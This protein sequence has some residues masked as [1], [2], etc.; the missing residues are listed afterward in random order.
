LA[1]E[2][3]RLRNTLPVEADIDKWTKQVDDAID[4]LMGYAAGGDTP[5][6]LLAAGYLSNSTLLK[7]SGLYQ[8][9]DLALST[10]E[11]GMRKVFRAMAQA[12]VNKVFRQ[13][14]G[15]DTEL[16]SR[17]NDALNG[18][19][20]NDLRFKWL[21][22]YAEDNTDLTRSSAIVGTLRNT[23]QAAHTVNGLRAAHSMLVNLNSGI[24]RDSIISALKGGEKDAALL[25]RF[26]MRDDMLE[27]SRAAYAANPDAALPAELQTH[28]ELVGQR[29]MD[30]LVQQTRTGET[31]HFA[32]LNPVGRTLVGYQSFALAGTNK[33]LRRGLENGF[34]EA[35][36]TAVLFMH[37]FPLACMTI[38]AKYAMDGQSDQKTSSDL[39]NDA[40]MS[41]SLMGGASIVLGMFTN[42]QSGGVA[43]LGAY[44]QIID[45]LKSVEGKGEMTMKDAS[46]IFPLAQEAIPLRIL[47]NNMGD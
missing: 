46:K 34:S 24:L 18:S 29:A 26:G 40:V 8:L 6:A 10:K 27:R 14:I 12:G 25:K 5:D 23:A 13:E 16:A 41:M 38:M 47:I 42:Q 21:H 30:Y 43:A 32:E 33:I 19:I 20:K 35:M 2:I 28:I 9:Q 44:N 37:Q 7:N 17:L 4:S 22:T 11:L 39:I 3:D 15:K 1:R 36:G 45:T 31:S